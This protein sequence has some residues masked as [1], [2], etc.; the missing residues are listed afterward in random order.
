MQELAS[1]LSFAATGCHAH[2]R[3][4]FAHQSSYNIK[5]TMAETEQRHA[6]ERE[7]TSAALSTLAAALFITITKVIV[8]VWTRSLGIL[9]EAADSTLD[10]VAALLTFAAVR[11]SGKPPD[12]SHPYGHGKVENLAALVETSLLLFTCGWIIYEA[13]SRLFFKSVQIDAN[14]WAFGVVILSMIIDFNRMRALQ[15]AAEKHESQ[16]LQASA[17]RF[18][19]DILT[20]SV[21][22]LGLSL[23][24]LKERIGGPAFLY[25]ADAVAGL[26]VALVVLYLG[27]QLGRQAV[28]VLLDTAPYGLSR[29]IRARAE[30]L[31][32][33]TS[34]PQVRVRRAGP[35]SFVDVVVE[36]DGGASFER[37]HDITAQLEQAVNTLVPRADIV[38]H[39][40]PGRPS[41]DL[42]ARVKSIAH[43]IGASAHSVW[44]REVDGRYHVELHLEVDRDLSL[45]KAHGLATQLESQLK[46]A[47]PDI[48]EVVAHIE[49]M[50]D[51]GSPGRPLSPERQARLQ[52]RIVR[53]VDAFVG[54]GACHDVAMW[55]ERHGWA[56]S[57]HCSLTPELSIQEAHDLSE[58]LEARIRRE[59]PQLRRV[60]IHLEP[61]E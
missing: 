3:F 11:I 25:H 59:I 48:A 56:V 42:A 50:G 60:V 55:E 28:A 19:T 54:D 7:K 51:A 18:R 38:V 43:Q 15:R 8:G 5:G 26:G 33:V 29:E 20:S 40:E 14:V 44:A 34:C 10:V 57:L 52:E 30:R 37:A 58:R 31:D 46:E 22:L 1:L 47:V 13:I 6:I 61:P 27:L 41:L 24:K 16:A 9:A 21:V 12:D 2:L 39:Y 35:D 23:V 49:P 32:G 4:G 36:I 45:E 53:L 17:L